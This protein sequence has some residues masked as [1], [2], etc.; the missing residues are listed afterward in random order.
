[1]ELWA[2]IEVAQVAEFVEQ[3]VVDECRGQGHEVETEVDGVLCRAGTPSGVR[4]LDAHSLVVE[5]VFDSQSG[6]A[7]G[8]KFLCLDA[9]L[10]G[11]HTDEPRLMVVEVGVGR[12][13]D[14]A[15]SGAAVEMESRT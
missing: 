3:N 8:Q 5:T 9:Q 13:D 12:A 2:V 10:F 11:D 15:E 1:M 14:F 4:R 6:E 7:L